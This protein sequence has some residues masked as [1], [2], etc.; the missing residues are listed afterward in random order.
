MQTGWTLVAR[1]QHGISMEQQGSVCQDLACCS[2]VMGG[3]HPGQGEGCPDSLSRQASC[4]EG[5]EEPLPMVSLLCLRAAL[6][7]SQ[8]GSRSAPAVTRQQVPRALW[9]APAWGLY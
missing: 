4:P 3:M 6:S 1:D 5:T 7:L 2:G 8:A 9:A